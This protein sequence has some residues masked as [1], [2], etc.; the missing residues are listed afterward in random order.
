[1]ILRD[2]HLAPIQQRSPLNLSMER[3]SAQK[4]NMQEVSEI[5]VARGQAE[6]FGHYFLQLTDAL[7]YPTTDLW[8]FNVAVSGKV[9]AKTTTAI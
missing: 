5:I 4:Q 1:M 2:P 9:I 6:K 3:K 8:T 7:P